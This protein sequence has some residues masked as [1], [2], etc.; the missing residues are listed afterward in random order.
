V[1]THVPVGVSTHS[2]FVCTRIHTDTVRL[3]ERLE[4]KMAYSPCFLVEASG[5]ES[6]QGQDLIIVGGLWSLGALSGLRISKIAFF[7]S[8]MGS[9]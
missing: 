5:P 4:E 9:L 7:P 3:E 8:E 1:H 2:S 6:Q